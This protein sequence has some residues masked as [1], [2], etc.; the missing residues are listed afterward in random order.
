MTSP[1]GKMR[2]VVVA[3]PIR[4]NMRKSTAVPVT[5]QYKR[6]HTEEP[7]WRV[8]VPTPSGWEEQTRR[9]TPTTTKRWPARAATSVMT[10]VPVDRSWNITVG[11]WMSRRFGGNDICCV[12]VGDAGGRILRRDGIRRYDT[13]SV[14]RHGSKRPRLRWRLGRR[15]TGLERW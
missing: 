2:R 4:K 7:E 9:L 1:C 8:P 13:L 14:R 5:S 6:S 11:W 10:H 15:R 12:A 3:R